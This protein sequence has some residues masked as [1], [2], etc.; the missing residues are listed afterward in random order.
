MEF[1]LC[2]LV[3]ASERNV[4]ETIRSETEEKIC[5]I[6]F[7]YARFIKS[8]PDKKEASKSFANIEAKKSLFPLQMWRLL[9]DVW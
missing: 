2:S 1:N 5:E 4:F 7:Y 6:I 8:S 3:V 9:Y